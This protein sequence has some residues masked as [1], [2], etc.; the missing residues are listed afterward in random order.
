MTH[1]V[2]HLSAQEFRRLGHRLIDWIAAY[3]EGVG[4]R[5]VREYGP[6]G[7]VLGAMKREAPSSGCGEAGWDQLFAFLDDVVTPNLLHWQSPRF[8]GYFPCNASFA[9]MLGEIAAA[10]LGVNGM[11]WSTS[12]AVTEVEMRCMDWMASLIGLPGEFTFENDGATG[13]GGGCIAGTA[14]ESTLV[15]LLAARERARARG[16][17]DDSMTLYASKHAHSSIVKAAMIAGLA[18][19]PDDRARLRLIECDD[20]HAMDAACLMRAMD[21]DRAAGLHP[22]WVCATIGT[23]SSEAV[24]PIAAISGVI[25]ASCWLHVDAAFTGASLVCEEHRWMIAGVERADSLCFNPHKWLLVN[26]DCDCFWT[27]DR[28]SVVGALSILPEYLRNAATDAGSVIDYRDWQLPLGRRFRALKL[29]FVLEQYGAAG[30][31]AHIR[32][33]VAAARWLEERVRESKI[34]DMAAPRVTSLVCVRCC[35]GDEATKRAMERLNAS[36]RSF[37]SHT[38]LADATGRERFVLRIAIGGTQTTLDHVAEL[39]SALQECAS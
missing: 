10:G 4:D 9:G 20:A 3:H 31:K 24:D 25:D 1:D 23:T 39:W 36:G 15:S 29:M 8:F 17:S 37:V 27:R 11:M 21:A 18:R 2:P 38:M 12:P 13:C 16:V 26:F 33:H 28:G 34:F 6:P 7:T 19:G 14:S 35:A 22:T 30:L 5:A 32:E